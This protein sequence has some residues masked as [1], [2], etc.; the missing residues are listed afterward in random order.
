MLLKKTVTKIGEVEVTIDGKTLDFELSRI[1]TGTDNE[2]RSGVFEGGEAEGW[3]KFGD[4]HSTIF[5]GGT[6]DIT[7]Q[8][9]DLAPAIFDRIKK[10]REWVRDCRDSGGERSYDEN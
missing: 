8:M 5:F 1:L 9:D 7:W 10:V 2:N 6:Y 3:F 4:F